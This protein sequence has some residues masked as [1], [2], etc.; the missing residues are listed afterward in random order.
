MEYKMFKRDRT[1]IWASL[2]SSPILDFYGHLKGVI[3][4]CQN[5]TDR[6]L[7]Q[8]AMRESEERLRMVLQ[9]STT[10]W[11]VWDLTANQITADPQAKALFG[12]PPDQETS[13]D[14]FLHTF[15]PEEIPRILHK[16]PAILA[17]AK[18]FDNEFHL[19][20][21]DGS[22][23]WI[24][25]KGHAFAD[26]T[27]QNRRLMGLVMDI[28]ARKR[29]EIAFERTVERLE[30]LFEVASR[31]MNSPQPQ[32]IVE[33]LCQ[34]VMKHL[35]CDIFFNFLIDEKTHRLHLNAYSGVPPELALEYEWI[36]IGETLCGY[37]AE[38]RH[39]LILN[40]LQQNI[41]PRTEVLRSTGV[42]AYAGYPL[43][44]R[45]H[46]IGTLSFA[47][48]R[49]TA[50]Q[51][52]ELTLMLAVSD[53][54]AIA[55]ERGQLLELARQSAADADAA[56]QA[57][58]HFLAV[59]SHE[60]R[61]PLTPVVM[62]VSML[63]NRSDLDVEIRQTLEMVRRNTE[64]EAR[65]IDDLLDMTR[66]ARGK[67]ELVRHPAELSGI[68][69]HAIEVCK[70]DIETRRLHFDVD[71]G[72][73]GTYWIEADVARLQQV[74][75]NLLK[76]AIKFTPHD[77]CVG[78]RCWPD[79]DRV[80]IEVNDSGIGI[81]PESLLR[82]FNAFEQEEQ[83]ITQQFGGLGLGLAISKTLVEMHGGS[84]E[85]Q[86]AGRDQG[87]TFRIRL[88][89]VAPAETSD[90]PV[91]EGSN[92]E[93]TRP[94]KILLV[95]DHGVTARMMK[96]VL[97]KEGHAVETAGD[98]ATALYYADRNDFDLLISDLGLPDGSGHD[99]MRELRARGH[100]FPGIALSGYGQEEN[101][102]R[103]YEVGFA[104]HLTKPASREA[105]IEVVASVISGKT[106][107][108]ATIPPPAAATFDIAAALNQCFGDREILNQMIQYFLIDT[109]TL[110]PQ[111]RA[112][113][114]KGDLLELGKLAH[115]LKGTILHLGADS[116][117]EAAAQVERTGLNGC[118]LTQAEEAVRGLE[119][120]CQ[121]LK[122]ALTE[123]QT[124]VLATQA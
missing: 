119:F 50:F 48:K 66:I 72:A 53:H 5:I 118:Q 95:E 46:L 74:F 91:I 102:R 23:H 10:G 35:D 29:V 98:V 114:E 12:I 68:I 70:P 17:D 117:G 82:I 76:N 32:E 19:I 61:T 38:Q 14:T 31:L 22:S 28:T 15:A 87:A 2:T 81:E 115:R 67:I 37:A 39:P 1:P 44:S 43:I 120:Q 122:T 89:L 33:Y 86:S 65:L 113:L 21:R 78:I 71:L 6:K 62:G 7:A 99:L 45:E 60:L 55:I 54:V 58:D 16:L 36:N 57:K 112:A 64:M 34:Q 79:N 83:S 18:D 97:V 26:E 88:P 63:Q 101:I 85:A 73:E 49:K 9:A 4:V 56:N 106:S 75:W 110:L 124:T 42:T 20:W 84:I 77:G 52:E 123:Y 51:P 8:E 41:D 109:E 121:L 24:Q 92:A 94:L 93:T 47:S 40:D 105:L 96:I 108:S 25:A 103:S 69:F 100:S 11:W 13:V 3:T 111:I 90:S 104:A 59:L 116:A 27:G 107:Q 30:L 80:I